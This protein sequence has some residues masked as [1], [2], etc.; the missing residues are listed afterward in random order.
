MVSLFQWQ[1]S[2]F[3]GEKRLTFPL[4]DDLS[5]LDARAFH[6]ALKQIVTS[7]VRSAPI[8]LKVGRK[9]I[10]FMGRGRLLGASWRFVG[11]V[12]EGETGSTVD[13]WLILPAV[14][15]AFYL[16]AINLLLLVFLPFGV[17]LAISKVLGGEIATFN[18][19]QKLLAV[20][21][22]VLCVAMAGIVGA[23]SWISGGWMRSGF[24]RDVLETLSE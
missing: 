1:G 21:W 24:E 9:T 17:A 13:G 20:F 22:P 3:L 2:V 11:K 8:E 16:F 7:R 15:R 6:A 4:R 10:W 19:S 14:A 18:E 12:L 23:V 5:G